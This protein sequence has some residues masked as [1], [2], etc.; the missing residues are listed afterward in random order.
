[1][2]MKKEYKTWILL[3]I[4]IT[5]GFLSFFVLAKKFS[6]VRTY[7]WI[8]AILDEKKAN[9]LG[10]TASS[11]VIANAISFIPGD[12]GMPLANQFTNLSSWL[13]LVLIVLYVEKYALTA[14]GYIVFKFVI[15]L[16]MLGFAANLFI[17][18]PLINRLMAKILTLGVVLM[19]L[20]PTS[21]GIT[22]MIDDTYEE[23]M[24]IKADEI[25]NAD[26]EKEEIVEEETP[27]EENK[28]DRKWY[29]K[30]G[31][32][33]TE[34]FNSAKDAVTDAAE[35]VSSGSTN[36]I[37]RAKKALDEFIEATVVM[38]V[39]SCVVPLLT[40]LLLLAVMKIVLNVDV[41][42]P[43]VPMKGTLIKS[44]LKS[45]NEIE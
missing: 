22:K 17:K 11:T 35:T 39:T 28:E 4:L 38:V 30:V 32:W 25:I 31:D 3:G 21:A 24:N 15:P 33:F 44:H 36:L 7:D 10:L 43:R 34:M 42:T 16:T 5:V 41:G 27:V 13:V 14:I 40:L 29:E 8:F 1:M 18:S 12:A 23:S 26:E 20:V 37:N 2:D 9:V 6:D 45:G 19:L